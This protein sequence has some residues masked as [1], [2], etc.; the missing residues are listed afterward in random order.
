MA[1][2]RKDAEAH[3]LAFIEEGVSYPSSPDIKHYSADLTIDGHTEHLEGK[4]EKDVLASAEI[5]LG[6]R[7]RLESGTEVWG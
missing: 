1:L 7:G 5:L 4:S 2:S 6:Q 3:G